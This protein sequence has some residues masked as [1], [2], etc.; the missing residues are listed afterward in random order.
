MDWE[1]SNREKFTGAIK[2]SKLCIL[3]YILWILIGCKP[4]TDTIDVYDFMGPAVGVECL[5]ES[6][7]GGMVKIKGIKSEKENLMVIDK[8]IFFPEN[9]FSEG[10]PRKSTVRYAFIVK[11]NQIIKNQNDIIET[12]LSM[13]G[14]WKIVG[15]IGRLNEKSKNYDW[16]K[17]KS[18]CKITST[19]TE[20]L[21]GE[22]RIVLAT[23]CITKYNSTI[24]TKSEKYASGIGLIERTI[25]AQSTGNNEKII[26]RIILLNIKNYNYSS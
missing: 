9:E 24:T 18:L 20:K 13:N 4:L 17:T 23:E 21:F 14:P 16:V 26:Y 15:K 5:Y 25:K 22:N 11:N 2:I 3:I 12:V 19:H 1:K 6:M 8:T 7:D 10:L